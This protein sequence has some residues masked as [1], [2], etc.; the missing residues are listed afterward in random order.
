[1]NRLEEMQVYVRVAELA[2]FTQAAH[3]LGLSKASVSGAIRTLESSLGVRLLQR[4]TRRVQMTVDGHAFYD[5]CRQVLAELDD[6]QA[7][8]QHDAAELSGHLRVDMPIGFARNI[9]LPRL[10]ELLHAHPRLTLD[11]SSTD[12]RVDIVKEGFDCTV[13]VGQLDD[14]ALVARPLGSFAMINC[15]SSAYVARHGVP[16][17]PAA[18]GSHR[19]VAYSPGLAGTREARFEYV[20]AG[21]Q[22]SITVP[23]AVAV[24]NTD[25][26]QAACLAGLGIIQVPEVGVR[27]LLAQGKLVQLLHSYQAAP[28]PVTLLYPERRHIAKRVQ[29]FMHWLAEITQPYVQ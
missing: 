13:R 9:V 26:Y 3:E 10:P 22:H 6:L 12:R 11:L 21:K 23:A 19:L 2:S 17:S 1:M 20:E 24:N 29:R 28:M 4:T 5:R 18:L 14:S 16:D 25:S 27:D 15:A 8:F 7:M